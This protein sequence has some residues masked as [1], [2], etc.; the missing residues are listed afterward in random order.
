MVTEGAQQCQAFVG[1]KNLRRIAECEEKFR[2][3]GREAR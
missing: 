3:V 1:Y 2:R